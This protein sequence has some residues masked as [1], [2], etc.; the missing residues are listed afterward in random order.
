MS[1]ALYPFNHLNE[2]HKYIIDFSNTSKI[3][4]I[5]GIHGEEENEEEKVDGNDFDSDED[6]I[7]EDEA[8]GN[9]PWIDDFHRWAETQTAH[10]IQNV[11]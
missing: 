2:G 1:T 11:H 6:P 5:N 8:I 7:I 10:L 3:D 9:M 4:V